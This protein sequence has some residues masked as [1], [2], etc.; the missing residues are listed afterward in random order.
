[1]GAATTPAADS[2]LAV[3]ARGSSIS[4]AGVDGAR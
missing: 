3:L 4:A 2:R 1:M